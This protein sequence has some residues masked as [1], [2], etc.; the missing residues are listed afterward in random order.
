MWKMSPKTRSISGDF[1]LLKKKGTKKTQC[2]DCKIRKTGY[3]IKN[4][5][6]KHR[7]LCCLK[8]GKKKLQWNKYDKT[9]NIMTGGK[10]RME[11]TKWDKAVINSKKKKKRFSKF[12]S[13]L[14]PFL[15]IYF[16]L[17]SHANILTPKKM[18]M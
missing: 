18:K 1:P 14:P 13:P 16:V 3:V 6:E 11:G 12:S 4:K 5:H 2:M 9:G 17:L 8:E 7:V 15:F 10:W